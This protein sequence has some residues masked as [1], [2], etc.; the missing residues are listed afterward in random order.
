MSGE[1]EL[2]HLHADMVRLGVTVPE[3]YGERK[4]LFKVQ[5]QLSF[6]FLT[7]CKQVLTCAAV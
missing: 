3:G 7:R 6:R 5:D 2:A 1:E 4:G